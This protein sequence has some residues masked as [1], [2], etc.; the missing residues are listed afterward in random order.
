MFSRGQLENA[1]GTRMELITCTTVSFSIRLAS[2]SLWVLN[3]CQMLSSF[4]VNVKNA[5]TATITN[6]EAMV[7]L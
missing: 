4:A 2:N 3:R 1:A 5:F 7:R 6:E